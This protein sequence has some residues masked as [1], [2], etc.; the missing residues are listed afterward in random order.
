LILAVVTTLRLV[1]TPLPLPL[2]PVLAIEIAAPALAGNTYLVVFHRFDGYA[3]T[4][5]AI[6]VAMGIVQIALLPYYRQA[7]FGP[8][9]WVSSFSYATA[10]TLAVRWINHELPPGADWWRA[11]SVTVATGVVAALA[12]ATARAVSRGQFIS[13][14][15]TGSP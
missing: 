11:A 7:P 2:R 13:R 14:R 4:L 8:A 15:T 5:A 12:L 9:F 10:A 1:Q 3:L 6:T